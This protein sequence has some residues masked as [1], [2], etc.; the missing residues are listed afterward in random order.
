MYEDADEMVVNLNGYNIVKF[1]INNIKYS[2]KIPE[3][4]SSEYFRYEKWIEDWDDY[5]QDYG[6]KL[7]SREMPETRYLDDGTFYVAES[8]QTIYLPTLFIDYDF[9]IQ[10]S[11]TT[12][13]GLE[14][15]IQD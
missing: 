1:T 12:Q 6:L 2:A 15:D 9:I 13:T 8:I 11:L 10:Q 7:F 3:Y 14:M 5:T 4:W